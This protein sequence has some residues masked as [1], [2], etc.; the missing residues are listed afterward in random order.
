MP[1]SYINTITKMPA[2]KGKKVSMYVWTRQTTRQSRR[3][4]TANVVFTVN[5]CIYIIRL[6]LRFRD[7]IFQSGKGAPR[8][9]KRA[10]D[11]DE[12]AL[13]EQRGSTAGSAGAQQVGA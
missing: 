4:G 3:F 6:E 9:Q 7:W 11:E 13:G 5:I 8:E 10:E 1:P 12:G 2:I